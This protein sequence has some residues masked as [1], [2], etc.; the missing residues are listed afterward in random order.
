MLPRTGE[1]DLRHQFRRVRAAG[2]VVEVA[3]EG[4]LRVLV[5][6]RARPLESA[7]LRVVGDLVVPEARDLEPRAHRE[8]GTAAAL[9]VPRR[10]TA[11]WA[12]AV[13]NPSP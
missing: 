4:L 11:R 10:P 7:G 13:R 5:R 12:S 9:G 2:D 3:L 6:Q 1:V 8:S